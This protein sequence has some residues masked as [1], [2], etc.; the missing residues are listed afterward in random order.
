MSGLFSMTRK[1]FLLS[2]F[3]FCF[4]NFFV[5][6][7]STDF[8]EDTPLYEG[9]EIDIQDPFEPVNRVV[10]V[11]NDNLDKAVVVPIVSAYKYFFPNFLQTAVKNVARN[12]FSPIRFINFSLQGEGEKAVKTLFGFLVNTVFGF[13]GTVNV[14]EKVGLSTE[15]TSFGKTLK[16]WGAKTGPY[17]VLPIFGSTTLR[18][19]VGTISDFQMSPATELILLKYGKR[20]RRRIY[21]SMYCADLLT[22]RVQMLEILNDLEKTSSDKYSVVRYAFMATQ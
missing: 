10:F 21:N 18:G 11:I 13:F 7:E 16:K 20:S 19:L 6:A 5:C 3:I 8:F 14:A 2:V 22:I 4:A 9:E 12:F 1:I 17:I 15:D